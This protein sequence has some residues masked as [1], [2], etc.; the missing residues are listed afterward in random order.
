MYTEK[1][2]RWQDDRR[3]NPQH[4]GVHMQAARKPPAGKSP[5]ITDLYKAFEKAE[6]LQLGKELSAAWTAERQTETL[7]RRDA[8]AAEFERAY[9]RTSRIV[10]KIEKTPAHTLEGLRVKARAVSWCHSGDKIS[11]K[12]QCA[13][14]R[15]DLHTTD[16]RLMRAIVGDLLT[17]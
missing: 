11:I 10:R 16:L 17:Y 13:N 6:L 4:G 8:P 15:G 14:A 7:L 1:D 12:T 3:H 9:R 5:S 2:D